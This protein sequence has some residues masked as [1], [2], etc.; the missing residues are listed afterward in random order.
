LLKKRSIHLI[1]GWS[2]IL[3]GIA[4]LV[5][6]FLQGFLFLLVGLLFLAREYPWASRILN[7]FRKWLKKHFPKAGKAFH[8]AEEYVDTEMQRMATQK[9]YFWKRLWM[10]V[11]VLILLA[12]IGYLL[13]LLF[14]WLK[15]LIIG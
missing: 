15:Y 4:G 1:A 12:G 7:W 2:F 5:L 6:P 11:G 8:Q 10:I 9:G 3:L 13:S 14:H